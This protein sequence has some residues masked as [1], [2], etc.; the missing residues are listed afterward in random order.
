M[1]L[2]S[3]GDPTASGFGIRRAGAFYRP[4]VRGGFF[5]L[6]FEPSLDIRPTYLDSVMVLHA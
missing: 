2:P 6:F 1:L 4:A 5:V 3:S